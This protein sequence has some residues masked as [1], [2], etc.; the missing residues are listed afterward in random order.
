MKITDTAIF[1][2]FVQHPL[3][4]FSSNIS[5]ASNIILKI[6]SVF[7]VRWLFERFSLQRYHVGVFEI[8][9]FVSLNVLLFLGYIWSS[10]FCAFFQFLTPVALSTH[11][12][13][14]QLD[15]W[16][17]YM[18]LNS[19]NFEAV[20]CIFRIFTTTTNVFLLD[21]SDR[22]RDCEYSMI[23]NQALLSMTLILFQNTKK[24]IFTRLKYTTT[25]YC[26]ALNKFQS[27]HLQ[28][29]TLRHHR[30]TGDSNY[31][32]F[33]SLFAR[34]GWVFNDVWKMQIE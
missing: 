17:S 32:N 26:F 22:S 23:H 27:K 5:P 33:Y 30:S 10:V 29:T 12:T 9:S 6:E 11:V 24:V 15:G 3:M 18:L 19:M 7:S 1:R 25:L 13:S 2:C 20:L 4:K 34:S 16:I 8:L 21:F 14:H 28:E 31:G